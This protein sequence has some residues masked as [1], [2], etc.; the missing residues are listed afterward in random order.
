VAPA[1][2]IDRVVLERYFRTHDP[3]RAL[4]DGR[5]QRVSLP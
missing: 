1:G 5:W 3:L 4:N 2:F